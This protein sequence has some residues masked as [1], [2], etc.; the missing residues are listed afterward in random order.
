MKQNITKEL[1][2]EAVDNFSER[3]NFEKSIE[4]MGELLQ[5]IQKYKSKD[6]LANYLEIYKE[7]V[8]VSICVLM[9]KEFIERNDEQ[10]KYVDPIMKDKL[11]RF[12]S[13]IEDRKKINA[14]SRK[15]NIR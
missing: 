14:E 8:D 11:D 10:N 12:I 3:F 15:S 7:T 9:M 1:I 4:E 13:T 6:S 2:N 5:A